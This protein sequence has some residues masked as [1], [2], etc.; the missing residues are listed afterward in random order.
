MK[1]AKQKIFRNASQNMTATGGRS[2]IRTAN[3]T[4]PKKNYVNILEFDS[5]NELDDPEEQSGEI[6][7]SHKYRQRIKNLDI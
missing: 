1:E 4:G 7:L 5:E 2:R 6:V 3:K